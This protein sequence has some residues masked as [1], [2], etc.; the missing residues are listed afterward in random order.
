MTAHE[1]F[2]AISAE[3]YLEGEKISPVRH[4]YLQGEV[5]AM[6]GATD[7]H[8]LI[9]GNLY[10]MLRNHLRGSGRRGYIGGMKARIEALDVFHYPDVMVTC[11]EQDNG[12]WV[13]DGNTTPC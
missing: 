13:A 1:R 2:D 5:Y 3:E 6:A 11:D 4:W 10:A 12:A 8:E 9:A 7:A